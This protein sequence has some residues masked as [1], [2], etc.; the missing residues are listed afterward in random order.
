MTCC[1]HHDALCAQEGI[2][3][4]CPRC[5]DATRPWEQVEPEVLNTR[6]LAAHHERLLA[7]YLA[8]PAH[9]HERYPWER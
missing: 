5:P 8:S 9:A 6:T 7:D 2:R 1:E 4:C 3:V